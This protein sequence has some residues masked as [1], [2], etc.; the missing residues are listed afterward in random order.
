MKVDGGRR[1]KLSRGRSSDSFPS[2]SPNG[3]LLVFVR[4]R[5][6]ETSVFTMTRGGA[7]VR[8]LTPHGYR[9]VE[10]AWSPRGDKIAFAGDLS[11]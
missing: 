2:W 7:N 9:A 6:N 4:Q 10:P 5:G 11:G 3:R 1:R 8:R